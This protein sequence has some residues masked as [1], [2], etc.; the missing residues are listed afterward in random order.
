MKAIHLVCKYHREC[1]YRDGWDNLYSAGGQRYD[2]GYWF[3]SED[4]A[5]KLVAGWLYLHETKNKR[6]GFGGRII[7]FKIVRYE[8]A[9]H[10]DR[11]L[12]EIEMSP[13]AVNQGWRGRAYGIVKASRIVE[14]DLPHELS[15]GHSPRE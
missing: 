3:I 13:A 8:E 9:Y 6:S 11:I 12:F 4:N 7:G 2:S 15:Q 14:A 1:K 5:R 10:K